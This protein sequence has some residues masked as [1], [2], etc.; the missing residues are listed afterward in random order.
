[1]RG[2]RLLATPLPTQAPSEVLGLRAGD[3]CVRP[4][5]GGRLRLEE[6]Y[7]GQASGP[8]G[9]E[10]RCP[11]CNRGWNYRRRVRGKAR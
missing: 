2:D 9:W 5:C 10:L 6:V 7:D 8:I 3:P 4:G 1:M 11:W